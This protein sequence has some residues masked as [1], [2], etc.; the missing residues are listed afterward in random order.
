MQTQEII[1]LLNKDRANELI[2]ILQYMNHHY[3]VTG[4]NFTALQDMFKELGIVEMRHA[5]KLAE[6]ISLLGGEPV[7]RT[8]ALK[9]TTNLTVQ[10]P[11]QPNQM[12]EAN[13]DYERMAI[14][15]YTD[16]IK[17]IGSNDPVTTRIL[18]DILAEEEE[19]ANNLQSWLGTDENAFELRAA[20]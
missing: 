6:R 2:A 16:H 8:D 3:R 13:L 19:H 17:M 4:E 18:E 9:E 7:S 20:G 15:D 11:S 1:D 12:V 5:E 14:N 10:D